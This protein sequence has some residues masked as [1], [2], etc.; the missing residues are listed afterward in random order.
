MN[1]RTTRPL[2]WDF[3]VPAL[4]SILTLILVHLTPQ[5]IGEFGVLLG[6]VLVFLAPGYLLMVSLFPAKSDLSSRGRVLMS[7][8]LGSLLA[9]LVS[10][11]LTFTPRGLQPASVATILSFFTLFLTAVAYARWSPL[12]RRKRFSAGSERGL[13]K[14]GLMHSPKR[15]GHYA[16]VLLILLAIA[17][18]FA[19]FA[20]NNGNHWNLVEGNSESMSESKSWSISENISG[21]ISENL[22]GNRSNKTSLNLYNNTSEKISENQSI[23]ADDLSSGNNT[24]AIVASKNAPVSMEQK[25]KVVIL[26]VDEDGSEGSSA[27]A[28]FAGMKAANINPVDKIKNNGDPKKK[29]ILEKTALGDGGRTPNESDEK[30]GSSKGADEEKILATVAVLPASKKIIEAHQGTKD[31][32]SSGNSIT[33]SNTPIVDPSPLVASPGENAKGNSKADQDPG[34]SKAADSAGSTTE[35]GKSQS[36]GSGKTSGTGGTI[37]SSPSK[38]DGSKKSSEIG[39]EINTWVGTR[40]IGASVKSQTPY[41]SKN[42]KYVNEEKG[43]RAVLGR[44]GTNPGSQ[45]DTGP[46]KAVK[47]GR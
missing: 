36:S 22:S 14:R 24:S 29:E 30:N 33:K 13:G 21:K 5:S 7:I 41:A 1:M 28:V 45:S 43:G 39:K 20:L 40:S 38:T 17:I 31:G 37:E 34:T 12:P 18:S 4:I 32:D 42:I 47:L 46:K 26:S 44:A 19:A 9:A 8:L 35:A 2:P 6:L 16:L 11:I 3:T 27:P 25:S 10:L 23:N 15:A